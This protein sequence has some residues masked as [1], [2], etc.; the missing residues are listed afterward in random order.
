MSGF[1]TVLT[2]DVGSAARARALLERAELVIEATSFGSV[3]T[4]A[5]RRARWGYGDVPEGL[6]RLSVGIEDPADLARDLTAALD[7]TR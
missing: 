3:H 7:A 4:M 5:E 1:G 2:F 6:I